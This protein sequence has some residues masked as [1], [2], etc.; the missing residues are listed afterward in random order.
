[1]NLDRLI[2]GAA[3]LGASDIHLVEDAEPF[4]RVDGNIRQVNEPPV[5]R[6]DLE[7]IIEKILPKRLLP[8]L[9]HNR[10]ADFSYQFKDQVRC[11][12]VIFYEQQKLRLV[13]RLIPLIVPTIDELELP[14]MLKTFA[15]YNLGMI[16]VTGPTGSGKS[17][18]L[19]A[20]IDNL[21]KSMQRTLITIEDPIEFI[22]SNQKSIIAQREV[23][24]DV[25]DFNSG[26]IQA[27][28]QD[29]DVL[30]VGEM[31]DMET[32]RT[33]IRASET[34]HLVLSTMHTTTA[35]HSIE[36]IIATFPQNEHAVLIEQLASNLRVILSQILIPRHEGR[37][38]VAAM[39]IM[40][41]NVAISKLISKSRVAEIPGV[42]K[43]GEDGMQVYDQ[44][45][46]QLAREKKISVQEGEANARD[47]HAFLRY[48]KGVSA[49]S[50][51]GGIIDAF[52]G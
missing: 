33:A 36:R 11:R 7:Q 42:M 9:E 51:R 48:Y 8:T 25:T 47:V 23:G 29:P 24:E 52:T 31:R 1:M 27:M 5:L 38:R 16:L 41:A 30:L 18:T 12:L 21:N 44:A 32:M 14:Q 15:N 4:F 34:G 39:E 19:A 49:S 37:G 13:L 45:L 10:G 35:V 20:V 6:T 2:E 43:T 22:H 3:K 46:G 50:D 40:I 17:S 28:R 26:L